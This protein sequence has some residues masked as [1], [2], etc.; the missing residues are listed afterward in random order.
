MAKEKEQSKIAP[1]SSIIYLQNK[2]SAKDVILHWENSR[3]FMYRSFEKYDHIRYLDNRDGSVVGLKIDSGLQN[4]FI[5]DKAEAELAT[6]NRYTIEQKSSD[7]GRYI[8]DLLIKQN[9]PCSYNPQVDQFALDFLVDR[10]IEMLDQELEA[11]SLVEEL[12]KANLPP[13]SKPATQTG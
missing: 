9:F 3:I 2:D 1:E 5:Q 11:V 8:L 7:L 13:D 12:D 10:E 6:I 4:V